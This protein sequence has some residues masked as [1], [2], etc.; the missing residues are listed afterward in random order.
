[1][2]KVELD[3]MEITLLRDMAMRELEGRRRD[4]KADDTMASKFVRELA[5]K[6][7]DALQE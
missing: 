6:L 5:T 2:T 1:M 3:V 4:G 7:H